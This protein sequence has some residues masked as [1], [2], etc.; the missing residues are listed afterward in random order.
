MWKGPK[1]MSFC[2]HRVW[3]LVTFLVLGSILVHQPESC[4][5]P[6]GI[7]LRLTKSRLIN[8]S[9]GMMES[10]F[11]ITQGISKVLGALC[12]EPGAET[13]TCMCY[14][15]TTHLLDWAKSR[16]LTTPN[17]GKDVEKQELCHYSN[18]TIQQLQSLLFAQMN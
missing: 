12:Q 4:L 16:T 14:Y 18:H 11:P 9:S 1:N 13:N 5:P 15:L 3:R 6:L 8:I 17:A 2:P 7:L 10:N